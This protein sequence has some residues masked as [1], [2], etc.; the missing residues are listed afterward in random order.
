VT[1]APVVTLSA[2]FGAGGSVVGP[3]VAELLGVPFL[4]RA[5]PV[6]VAKQL[7]VPLDE[8]LARDENSPHGLGRV[9]SAFAHVSLGVGW[10]PPPNPLDEHAFK[11]EAE[12]VIKAYAADGAVILG[13][14]A[15]LVLADHP[16]ALHVRLQG[17]EAARLAQAVRIGAA[18]E[19]DAP[20]AQRDADRARDAYVKQLYGVDPADP[21]HYHLVIDSTAIGLGACAELIA[22]A[23]VP[24]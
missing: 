1:V 21:R 19:A 4:D 18:E 9:L 12:K 17:S 11:E 23:A 22:T 6:A 10:A 8:A 20:R 13:R 5:I 24:S 16:G 7:A 14:A 15:A 2:G 3:R